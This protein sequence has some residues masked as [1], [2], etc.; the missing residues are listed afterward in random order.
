MLSNAVV[1][2]PKSTELAYL[3][4]G[5]SELVKINANI[6]QG[7]SISEDNNLLFRS[8]NNSYIGGG[9]G[10]YD[11]K[12]NFVG[13]VT[14]RKVGEDNQAE[15][16]VMGLGYAIQTDDI[17]AVLTEKYSDIV[18]TLVNSEKKE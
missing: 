16:L 14:Y 4:E 7:I 6:N 8:G 3:D 17:Q 12:G 15:N 11:I 10:L 13:M 5:F 18:L 9:S 2:H 1:A